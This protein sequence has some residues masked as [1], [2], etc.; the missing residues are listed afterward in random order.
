[1]CSHLLY[2]DLL[3]GADQLLSSAAQLLMYLLPAA[4]ASQPA[5]AAGYY[6]RLPSCQGARC[7]DQSIKR[8]LV[9]PDTGLHLLLVVAGAGQPALPVLLWSQWN[10]VYQHHHVLESF[11]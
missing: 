4:Q 10:G 7:W 1:M 11:P 9:D 8:Y 3:Y 2:V 6:K 5:S